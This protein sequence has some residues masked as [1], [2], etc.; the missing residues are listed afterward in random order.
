LSNRFLVGNNPITE[1]FLGQTNAVELQGNQY[2]EFKGE[3][4]YGTYGP[5]FSPQPILILNDLDLIRHVVGEHNKRW[6]FWLQ[7]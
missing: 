4:Y 1:S 5:G 3:K 2:K 6:V 7:S